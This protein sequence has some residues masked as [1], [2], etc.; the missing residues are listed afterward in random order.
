MS[1]ELADAVYIIKR[2]AVCAVAELPAPSGRKTLSR[3]TARLA[4]Q[5]RRL[6]LF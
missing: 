6:V 2:S 4:R 5:F 1:S 3:P